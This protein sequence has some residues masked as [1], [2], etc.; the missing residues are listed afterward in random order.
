MFTASLHRLLWRAPLLALA[1][2]L[3][4][5]ASHAIVVGPLAGDS[6]I[7]LIGYSPG[8]PNYELG[9]TEVTWAADGAYWIKAFMGSSARPVLEAGGPLDTLTI[10]EHLTVGAGPAWNAWHEMIVEDGLSFTSADVFYYGTT[11]QIDGL[12][13]LISKSLDPTNKHFNLVSFGFT[14]LAPGTSITI[15]KTVR[16]EGLDVTYGSGS[17]GRQD[18]IQ[19]RQFATVI[20]EPATLGMLAVGGGLLGLLRRKRKH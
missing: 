4:T 10:V 8:T 13:T 7:T 2:L 11:E 9:L 1:L 17:L 12:S 15:V 14:P 20:P 3:A 18:I 16:W 5:T 6:T 19:I